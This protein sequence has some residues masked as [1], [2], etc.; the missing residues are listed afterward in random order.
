MWSDVKR[1]ICYSFM[2]GNVVLR[3]YGSQT[4]VEQ[5]RISANPRLDRQSSRSSR[6]ETG[7]AVE[8]SP[9]QSEEQVSGA[10]G[11]GRRLT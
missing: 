7:G 2:V 9:E 5:Q 1:S 10:W 6:R 4:Q 8:G 3:K 11:R